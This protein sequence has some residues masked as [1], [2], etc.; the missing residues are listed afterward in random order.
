M[1]LWLHQA[2]LARF[3]EP[4]QRQLISDSHQCANYHDWRVSPDRRSID[5]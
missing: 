4:S 5:I 1:T 3:P 2:Q